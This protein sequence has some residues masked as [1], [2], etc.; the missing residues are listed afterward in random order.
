MSR[1]HASLKHL[2]VF[3]GD[4]CNL[5]CTSCPCWMI[6]KPPSWDTGR[7]ADRFAEMVDYVG[8]QCPS[9]DR[10]MVIGGEPFIHGGVMEYFRHQESDV[11]VSAYTNF[12]WES[13]PGMGFRDNI[14]FLTSLD[15]HTDELY[16]RIRRGRTFD[17]VQNNLSRFSKHIV[18]VD[19][20]VSKL[21]LPH[22][23]DIFAMTEEVGCTHHFMPMDARV[24]FF[25]QQIQDGFRAASERENLLAVRTS[26]QAERILLERDDL[27]YV[28]QFYANNPSPRVNAF[29]DFQRLYRAGVSHYAGD[30]ETSA[31]ADSASEAADDQCETLKHYMEVTFARDGRYIPF[32]HCPTLRAELKSTEGPAFDSFEALMDWEEHVRGS[33]SCSDSCSRTPYLKVDALRV[34]G[35]NSAKLGRREAATA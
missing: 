15:A 10:V 25:A 6:D 20:T 17:L 11:C 22:M 13:D 23:S 9:F 14:R 32:V 5:K 16:R 3:M 34:W 1:F 26:G 29:H 12:A 28:E 33:V 31:V 21:N 7:L 27:M 18:H 24:S 8:G 2:D 35:A 4:Q 19:T 30:E